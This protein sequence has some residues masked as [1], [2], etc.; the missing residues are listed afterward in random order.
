MYEKLLKELKKYFKNKDE[1]Y[2]FF[3]GHP[4]STLENILD[5][6][7]PAPWDHLTNELDDEDIDVEIEEDIK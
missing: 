7:K 4:L 5:E 2:L 3:D 1:D 6:T